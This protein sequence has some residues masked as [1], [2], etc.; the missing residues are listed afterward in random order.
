MTDY[1][2]FEQYVADHAEIEYAILIYAWSQNVR[3]EH[4]L[5]NDT[6]FVETTC[7]AKRD[8]DYTYIGDRIGLSRYIKDYGDLWDYSLEYLCIEDNVLT[9]YILANDHANPDRCDTE[10]DGELFFD[11]GS[12]F[13]IGDTYRD[14]K[15]K[16]ID[17]KRRDF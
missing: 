15:M 16:R 10:I 9:G 1:P 8:P 11:E 3:I 17:F 12:W 2:T 6:T 7:Y 5:D 4:D 14:G 13:E